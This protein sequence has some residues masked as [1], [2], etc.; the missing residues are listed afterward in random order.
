MTNE[1]PQNGDYLELEIHVTIRQP[2]HF[3]GGIDLTERAYLS[4]RDFVE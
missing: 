3:G 4:Q 1:R 2:N